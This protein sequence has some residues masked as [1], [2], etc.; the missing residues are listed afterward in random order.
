MMTMISVLICSLPPGPIDAFRANYASIKVDVQ[1]RYTVSVVSNADIANGQLW[2]PISRNFE[3][4]PRFT[5]NGRWS[6][7]GSTE[8]FSVRAADNPIVPN[9]ALGPSELQRRPDFEALFD[10]EVL[11]QRD[12]GSPAL[13]ASMTEEPGPL[14]L[15]KSPL[16]W[17]GLY[18][19]PQILRVQFPGASPEHGTARRG[20]ILTET[21]IYK[22]ALNQ[23]WYQIEIAYDPAISFLPRYMRKVVYNSTGKTF[24]N[25]LYITAATACRAGGFF[26]LRW[27]ETSFHIDNFASQYANYGPDT[28]LSA[29]GPVVLGRFEVTEFRDRSGPTRLDPTTKVRSLFTAGGKV[30]ISPAASDYSLERIKALAGRQLTQPMPPYSA[31]IDQGEARKYLG[32]PARGPRWYWLASVFAVGF[33]ITGILLWRWR[34]PV[35]VTRRHSTLPLWILACVALSG[36]QRTSLDPPHLSATF[37]RPVLLY[38]SAEPD[39]A[40]MLTLKNDGGRKLRVIKADGGCSCRRIDQSLFPVSLDPGESLPVSIQ[41][42]LKPLLTPRSFNLAFETD[43][44]VLE[45]SPVLL[46]LPTH[47]LSPSPISHG[48]LWEGEEWVFE[49]VLEG[50][51]MRGNHDQPP[52]SKSRASSSCSRTRPAPIP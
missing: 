16:F 9:P 19:F 25:E 38:D 37:S 5:V 29:S 14:R 2:E 35:G 51:S 4:D 41:L 12:N 33:V 43:Q 36:C 17:W 10:G 32:E 52:F 39:H 3:I 13:D 45:V 8:Y 26:P 42:E 44:G 21:E 6:C 15:G 11:A 23:G 1:Y 47:Q 48:G 34:K 22:K 30:S 50:F 24:I 28:A 7:D 18:P 31:L 46:A 20:G 40:M 27:I 49:I